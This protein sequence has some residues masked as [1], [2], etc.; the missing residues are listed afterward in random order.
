MVAVPSVVPTRPVV[1]WPASGTG[2]MSCL[3]IRA[4]FA[5]LMLGVQWVFLFFLQLRF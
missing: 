4:A 2:M 1:S 5:G 3:E